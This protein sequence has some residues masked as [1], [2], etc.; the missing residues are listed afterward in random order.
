MENSKKHS[1][2]QPYILQSGKVMDQVKPEIITFGYSLLDNSCPRDIILHNLGL[3][4]KISKD[5]GDQIVL[6]G[7]KNDFVRE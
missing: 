2:N 3:D 1:K 6:M 4:T 7:G 5:I